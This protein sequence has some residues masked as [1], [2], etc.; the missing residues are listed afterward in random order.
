MKSTAFFVVATL[1]TLWNHVNSFV[2]PFTIPEMKSKTFHLRPDA[3]V[4]FPFKNQHTSSALN[5]FPLGKQVEENSLEEKEIGNNERWTDFAKSPDTFVYAGTWALLVAFASILAPGGFNGAADTA[6]RQAI[7]ENPVTPDINPFFWAFFNLFVIIPIV[8]SC[9][10]SPRASKEGIPAGPPLF[11][12]AFIAYFVI[13]PYLALRKEP[14]SIIENPS[15]EL[16]WVTKNIWEN[17][18]VN[19]ATILF[20]LFALA[21]GAPG[22]ADPTTSWNGLIELFTTTQFGSVSLADFTMIT[23]IL[24]KEVADDYKIRC[25]PENVDKAPLIGAS[26]AL[27]PIV[28]AALYC[29]ARPK[30]E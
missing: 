17:K 15:T 21:T 19:Y 26:T 23:L 28:G 6:L 14:K 11:L 1:S 20:A 16:D 5:F 18:I 9:T 29:A 2:S 12:S 27:L 8:L 10:I 13:G 3:T 22:L 4:C 30:L 7:I 24:T 25:A